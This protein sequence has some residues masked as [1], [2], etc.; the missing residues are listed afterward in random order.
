MV[1]MGNTSKAKSH[2]LEAIKN[3]PEDFA[4]SE[5][6]FHLN[7]AFQE[8]A[9]VEKKRAKRESRQLK[10]QPG[11]AR[12]PSAAHAIQAAQPEAKPWSPEQLMNALNIIDNMIE[13]EQKKLEKP[14]DDG[15]TDI[16]TLLG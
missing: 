8:I 9:K 1:I 14:E 13:E 6:R 15:K 16:D 10:P 11:L 7:A 4:L 12:M 3:I 5:A 2:L